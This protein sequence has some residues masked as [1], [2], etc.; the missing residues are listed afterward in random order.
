MKKLL[1]S[2]YESGALGLLVLL[3]VFAAI[4][5]ICSGCTSTYARWGGERVVTDLEGRPL[6]DKQG[7]VQ[8]VKEPVELS[9]W[10]H[11]TDSLIGQATLGIRE[12]QVDFSLTNYT[13]QPSDELAKVIDVSLKGTA[14]LAAKVGAAIATSG[15]SIASDVVKS[16][17]KKAVANFVAKGGDAAKAT[18]SCEGGACSITDGTVTETCT[19]C[20]LPGW[21]E[22]DPVP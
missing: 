15:G 4:A 14:E 13:A 3:L 22:P 5:T 8:K 11:W 10:R 17:I 16:K 6:V 1:K 20:G 18:V 21:V 7:V 19:D 9:S 2:M 12:K